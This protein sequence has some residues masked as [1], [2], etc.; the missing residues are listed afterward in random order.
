M[1]RVLREHAQRLPSS[2]WALAVAPATW[3]AHFLFCYLYAAIHCAKAGRQAGLG[4]IR[5]EIGL[6]TLVA[7]AIVASVA[8]VAWAQS[9]VAGDAP[10]HQHATDEDRIR[11]LALAGL[12]LACLSAVA[13]AFTALPA[14]LIGDCR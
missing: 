5:G 12:L 6:A 14:F 7:L 13:I 3:A 2:L 11:F 1:I 4:A 9:R 8:F 10:P